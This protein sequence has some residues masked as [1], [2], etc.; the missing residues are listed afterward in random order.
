[1][2]VMQ[3]MQVLMV[4]L[5]GNNGNGSKAV[6]SNAGSNSYNV[7]GSAVHTIM[8]HRP[9]SRWRSQLFMPYSRRWPYSKRRSQVLYGLSRQKFLMSN[10]SEP[11]QVPSSQ[12]N[13][14][15]N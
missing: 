8:V 14:L 5:A 12:K 6:I 15:S 1:M 7:E 3:V 10:V 13:E 2:L 4:M 11:S 9:Q